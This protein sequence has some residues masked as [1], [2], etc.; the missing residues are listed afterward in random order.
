VKAAGAT[1]LGRVAVV[2]TL[3]EFERAL[4]GDR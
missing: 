1:D 4:A 3:G 2:G